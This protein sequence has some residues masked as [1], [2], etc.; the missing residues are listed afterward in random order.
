[1][2]QAA[3]YLALLLVLPAWL[4]YRFFL[5]LAPG[6]R[7]AL[8]QT[9]SHAFSLVPG[10]PGIVVRRAF[11]GLSLRRCPRTATIGFG[12]ILSTPEVEIGDFVYLGAYCTLGKV[13]L[14]DHVLLGSNVDIMSGLH[15]HNI[16]R[17]DVPIRLQGGR[18]ERVCIG[19]DVWIGNSAVVAADVGEQAV[20]AA[21]AVVVKP[22]AP[23]LIV[24]GNPARIL[25]QRGGSLATTGESAESVGHTSSAAPG[26]E[27]ADP[28]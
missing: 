15:Q 13:T 25:G 23:R 3:H 17:L 26:T 9:F 21:G 6:R 19:N 20:V 28:C 16:G 22:V 18:F 24:G 11:Y 2:K 4:L 1:M 5:V 10:I 27:Y 7:D 8:F 12:T 14:G